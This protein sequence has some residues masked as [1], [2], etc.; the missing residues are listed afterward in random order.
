MNLGLVAASHVEMDVLDAMSVGEELVEVAD[1]EVA[2]L[3]NLIVFSS[4]QLDQP[5]LN[6]KHYRTA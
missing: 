1:L 5:Q 6:A 4:L 2:Q 3:H